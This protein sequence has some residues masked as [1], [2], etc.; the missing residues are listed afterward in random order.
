MS[1]RGGEPGHFW[2]KVAGWILV[3]GAS[4]LATRLVAPH[5]LKATD[6]PEQQMNTLMAVTGVAHALGAAASW[7]AS[8]KA[9]SVG[10]EAFFRGGM[11]S[12]MVSTIFIP[13]AMVIAKQLEPIPGAAPAAPAVK[14]LDPK[15]HIDNLLSMLTAGASEKLA[16][17][18]QY[19]LSQR[20][21]Y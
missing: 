18:T 16:A 21:H 12:E 6:T 8:E 9:E 2:P 15:T 4:A 1:Y 13:G 20:S 7:Y 5:L 10:V 14:G 19:A 3:P 17:P 11:W